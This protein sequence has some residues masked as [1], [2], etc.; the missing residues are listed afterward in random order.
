M[1]LSREEKLYLKLAKVLLDKFLDDLGKNL[2]EEKIKAYT[3]S[4]LKGIKRGMSLAGSEYKEEDFFSTLGTIFGYV[5]S[6]KIKA[7][8]EKI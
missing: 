3:Y 8:L 2:E 5:F 7:Y 1:E 4:F 6:E